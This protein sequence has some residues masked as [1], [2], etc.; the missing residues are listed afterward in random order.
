MTQRIEDYAIVGDLQTAALIGRNGS[1]DWLCFPRFDSGSCFGALVGASDDGRWV[2]APADGGES[3]G[4]RYRDK[5]LVLETE[6]STATGRV[7]IID[8]MPPRQATPDIVRI[9]E[10]ME[11]SVELETELV[12]RFD[13]GSVTPWVRRLDDE[14]LVAI[15]GPDGLMLR[16]PVDLEPSGM[17]HSA[18]FTIHAGE[19]VPFVLT[20]FP[21]HERA[22]V[23]VDA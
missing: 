18:R 5:T 1:I 22:P 13:Y 7:R 4:R 20:W 16:T 14:T 21:S 3:A 19:R 10:G 6:W 15:A 12:M 9:V 17:R 2:I 11:G 23:P 8:F